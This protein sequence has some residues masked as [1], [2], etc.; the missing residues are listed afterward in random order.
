MVVVADVIVVKTL[1]SKLLVMLN[2]P[3]QLSFDL[4]TDSMYITIKKWDYA[5]SKEQDN[6]I[7]DYDKKENILWVEVLDVSK[8]E[9]IIKNLIY[10]WKLNII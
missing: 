9:N 2:I 8:N 3:F 1:V 7:I 4:E 6:L 5:Y 10:I